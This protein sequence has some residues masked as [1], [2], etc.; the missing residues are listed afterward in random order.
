[1]TDAERKEARENRR[2]RLGPT[3]LPMHLG[4]QS[5]GWFCSRAALPFLKSG[6][7]PWRPELRAE[8]E[9]LARDL[10][11]VD[12]HEF[13][14]AV[15]AEA[16]HRMGDFMDAV[17][18]Y[19]HFSVVRDMPDPPVVW[20]SGSARLL[21]YG[22]EAG[23]D[24]LN[25][26]PVL[27]TPS[28]IN[29][30]YIMDLTPKRSLMRYLA[31]HGAR[32]LMLDWGTP[33]KEELGYSLS[34]YIGG[35][36]EDALDHS[37]KMTGGPVGVLGY[38]MGGML[39]LALAHRRPEQ[40]SHL[41]LLATPWNF[42]A[43]DPAGVRV[44]SAMAPQIEMSLKLLGAL[45]V[46]MMQMMF[47]SLDPYLAARKFRRFARW[48]ADTERARNFVSLEDWLNDGVP[49]A[50]PVAKEL[51]VDWYVENAPYNGTWEVCGRPVLPEEV[52]AKTLMVIPEQD[53]I[54]PPA[55][56][57]PLAR[58]LPKAES[59][60][61]SAGHI[62]MVAGGRAVNTLYAPLSEWLGGGFH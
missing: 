17:R 4:L 62:G 29:R 34:D 33:G 57:E 31:R 25:G 47:A 42:H 53:Y 1:M 52:E 13:A 18:A 36:L 60:R 45:P 39:A 15:D 49:L 32:P 28:L 6:S 38:C 14:R 26:V 20:E 61:L 19:Q 3:P 21:D 43:G 27:V 12:L 40:V 35:L 10:E 54:V 50:G 24:G 58:R 9:R 48:D 51:L 23:S 16:V 5:L 2:E 55:S 46:E 44:L 56:S 30:S 22:A 8:A 7:L 11:G 41:A 37:V 59:W